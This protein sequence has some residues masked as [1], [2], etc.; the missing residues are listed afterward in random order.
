MD[1]R[2]IL[3]QQSFEITIAR[4][5]RQ[6]IENHNNFENSAIIGL[7]PRGTLLAKRIHSELSAIIG[8][9]KLLLGNLDV[10]FFRDDF[11]RRETPII[12]NATKMDFIIE[13]RNVILIDDVLYTGRTI[14]AGLDAML[15]FGRPRKVELL[16][17]I[18]RRYNRDLPIQP[19]YTGRSVDTI[20][21]EKVKVLWKETEG[22]D[23]VILANEKTTT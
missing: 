5:C 10:T 12:P 17:L 13:N 11:R 9:D 7:Q 15:A 18:D 4:L 19:D 8:N 20:S 6:L 23:E 2:V 1:Q 21:S 3:N 22:K 16:V 14:R